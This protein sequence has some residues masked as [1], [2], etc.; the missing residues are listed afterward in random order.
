MP[1][2]KELRTLKAKGYVI[3]VFYIFIKPAYKI[4]LAGQTRRINVYG[5][6]TYISKKKG[7]NNNKKHKYEYADKDGYFIFFR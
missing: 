7:V 4:I 6:K 2:F 5:K 3:A 1:F